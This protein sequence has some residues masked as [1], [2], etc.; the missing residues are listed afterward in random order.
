MRTLSF[1]A[2]I[3]LCILAFVLFFPL[4]SFSNE[5]ETITAFDL[6]KE[7]DT[8]NDL[9]IISPL[10]DIEFNEQYIPG[11]VNIPYSKLQESEKLPND[12]STLIVT[13]CLGPK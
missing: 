6:K 3:S 1:W 11:S 2:S 10:S 8:H 7:I 5:V 12:K 9:L 13:Y 4:T